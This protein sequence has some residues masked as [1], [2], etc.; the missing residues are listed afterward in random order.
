MTP[1]SVTARDGADKVRAVAVLVASALAGACRGEGADA[2]SGGAPGSGGSGGSGEIWVWDLP[3]DV[4]PPIVPVD[5]PM[6]AAKVELGRHLF[7]DP[8]L[9]HGETQSCAC[10]H[11]PALAFSDGR[12][13]A[14]LASGEEHPRSAPS[15]ANV[16]WAA[17]LGWANPVLVRLES[18]VIVPL[19][20]SDPEEL[21]WSGRE[22]EL[23]ARLAAEPIYQGLFDDAFPGEDAAV[24][25]LHVVQA[26]ASFERTLVSTDAPWDRFRAGDEAALD[27]PAQRG[28]AL[29]ASDRLS[30][31]RCHAGW[32]TTDAFIDATSGDVVLQFHNTGLYDV[33]SGAYPEPSPGLEA[34]TGRED[35]RGK[36]RAPTLRNIAVTAP[37]M[38]DGSVE[39]L[40]DVIDHYARGGRLIASGPD[41]GDG[42]DNPYKSELLHG[43]TLEPGEREDLLSFLHALTDEAFLSDPRLADPW[44]P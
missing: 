26:L 34:A 23:E 17:S 29:F 38:H 31:A 41:A 36:F 32:A 14:L 20:G 35:D 9:S 39:T 10:C 12:A 25:V 44:N 43:F 28:L 5:D 19:F 42:R 13:R 33:G 18:H 27:A 37:Y 7:F 6:S 2:G 1:C 11:R 16:A 3:P 8:R 40:D 22:R 21:G 15:L 30:C 24:T 4:P